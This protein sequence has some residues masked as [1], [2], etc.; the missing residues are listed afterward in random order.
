LEEERPT[1]IMFP[2]GTRSATGELQPFKKGAFVL[3][4]QTGADV[5]PTAILGSRAVMRKNSLL[6]HAGT[7]TIRF[8]TPIPVATLTM[9]QRD[10]LMHE[11]RDALARLLAAPVEPSN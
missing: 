5:V 9:D 11:T 4:I 10:E 1:V 3:A 6:I 8:G 2:E 7:V